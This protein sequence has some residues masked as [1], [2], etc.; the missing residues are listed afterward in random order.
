[1]RYLFVVLG[2]LLSASVMASEEWFSCVDTGDFWA[3]SCQEFTSQVED[4]LS[5][6]KDRCGPAYTEV[7]LP[8]R[9]CEDDKVIKEV[10]EQYQAEKSAWKEEIKEFAEKE[11]ELHA[12]GICDYNDAKIINYYRREFDA[13]KYDREDCTVQNYR[14]FE[15]PPILFYDC[16]DD[17]YC[18][19]E[20]RQGNFIRSVIITRE[21]MLQYLSMEKQQD[22]RIRELWNGMLFKLDRVNQ[23]LDG[24][25]NN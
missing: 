24:E 2:V 20:I 19:G 10:Y 23:V 1:M 12:F 7:L 13:E 25:K 5:Y 17:G 22:E 18:Y 11:K 6:L 16:V 4:T 9:I 15:K 8:G 3:R 14:P 21:E